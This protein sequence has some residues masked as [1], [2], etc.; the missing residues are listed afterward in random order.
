MVT[1]V[2]VV[3]FWNAQPPI[4]VTLS[5]VV[6]LITAVFPLPNMRTPTLS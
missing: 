4:L 3:H 1:L 2:T 5:G 6:T